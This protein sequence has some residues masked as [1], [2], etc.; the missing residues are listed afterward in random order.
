MVT[1]ISSVQRRRRRL[2]WKESA[3]KRPGSVEALVRPLYEVIS[4]DLG[5][6]E[7]TFVRS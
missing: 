1:K 7:V 5:G 6:V 2:V 3:L 4:A